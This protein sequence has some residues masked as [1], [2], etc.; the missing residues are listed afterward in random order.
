MPTQNILIE[1]TASAE[2]LNVGIDALLRLGKIDQETADKFT[3]ANDALKQRQIL[4][5]GN[6]TAL[7]KFIGSLTNAQKAAVGDTYNKT[8]TQIKTQLASVN[9]EAKEFYTE[10][11]RNATAHIIPGSSQEELLAALTVLGSANQSLKE[12]GGQEDVVV[13]KTQRATTQLREMRQELLVLEESGSGFSQKFGLSFDQLS[14]KAAKLQDR[15]GDTSARIQHMASDTFPLQAFVGAL[16]GVA[17][18]FNVASGAAILFGGNQEE[19]QQAILKVQGAMQILNGLESISAL[20][21]DQSVAKTGLQVLVKKLF[22]KT[23]QE[24]VVS[25]QAESESHIENA[26]AMA[27][28][29]AARLK[30]IAAIEAENAAKAAAPAKQVL[31]EV[32]A[33]ITQALESAPATG[34]SATNTAVLDAN[35]ASIEANNAAKEQQI[36]V[37]EGQTGALAGETTGLIVESGATDK[38][39]VAQVALNTAM[40]LNP[41][42]LVLAGILALAA[43]FAVYEL[44]IKQVS[45][46]EENRLGVMEATNEASKKAADSIAK[47]EGNLNILLA[48]AKNVSLSTTERQIALDKITTSY[49]EYLSSLTLDN[50][51]TKQ[52]A[53]LIDNQIKLLKERAFVQAA[54]D[55]YVEKL[56]KVVEAETELNRV[57]EEG[58]TFWEKTKAAVSGLVESH[59]GLSLEEIVVAKKTQDVTEATKK[60]NQGFEALQKG[61]DAL[62][63]GFEAGIPII[64]DYTQSVLAFQQAA[65]KPFTPFIPAPFKPFDPAIFDKEKTAALAAAQYRI[66]VAKKG[67]KEEFNARRDLANLDLK[68]SKDDARILIDDKL[69]AEGKYI[70]T[71]AGLDAEAR[72]KY[73][74][75]T[76]AAS[77]AIVLQQEALGKEGSEAF[78]NARRDVLIKTAKEARTQEGITAGEI[79]Q[80]NAQLNLDLLNL[81]IERANKQLN[82]QKTLQQ[83]KLDLAQKGG[84]DELNAQIAILEIEK[85]IEINNTKGNKDAIAEIN[86]RFRITEFEKIQAFNQ[87]VNEDEIN[88]RIAG[89]NDNISKLRLQGEKDTDVSIIEEKKKLIEQQGALEIAGVQKSLLTESQK[90]DAILAIY[91][92]ELVDKKALEDAKAQVELDAFVRSQQTALEAQ[93]LSITAESGLAAAFGAERNKINHDLLQNELDNIEVLRQANLQKLVEKRQNQ[94]DFDATAAD[95]DNKDTQ[96]K[97]NN[98]ERVNQARQAAI[99]TYADLLGKGLGIVFDK[100]KQQLQES[101]ANNQALLDKKLIS[102]DEF[103]KRQKKIKQDEAAIERRK[104]LLD[105]AIDF[106]KQFFFIKAQVA[107]LLANPLTSPL[108]LG[109]L[110]QLGLIVASYAEALS[111]IGGQKFKKGKINIIGPGSETSDSIP[112]SIS[113]HESVINAFST[114]ATTTINRNSKTVKIKNED[115]LTAINENRLSEFLLNIILET[116]EIVLTVPSLINNKYI[117]KNESV[118][119]SPST[120]LNTNGK[121]INIKNGD[122][123]TAISEHHFVDLL[124]SIFSQFDMPEVVFNIPELKNVNKNQSDTTNN[125]I[126]SHAAN[127]TTTIKNANGKTISIKNGDVLNAISENNFA[128]F[129]MNIIPE[130]INPDIKNISQLAD[131]SLSQLKIRNNESN[132]I[133]QSSYNYKV[134]TS[135]SISEYLSKIINTAT[136][137][138]VRDISTNNIKSISES[139]LQNLFYEYLSNAA[140][141]NSYSNIYN[142]FVTANSTD[143]SNQFKT[144]NEYLLSSVPKIDM[145]DFVTQSFNL[146]VM[147]DLPKWVDRHIAHESHTTNYDSHTEIDYE[148]L[149]KEV[150]KHFNKA[151][152]KA[153]GVEIGFDHDGMVAFIKE[154]SE[155]EKYINRRRGFKN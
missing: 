31:G 104:A 44:A 78:F 99:N 76:I 30:A 43:G 27:I 88:T 137:N 149:G 51:L 113:N 81:D 94:D 89:I 71:V 74:K 95:L 35:T 50:V 20:I 155:M 139:N 58:V 138:I 54:Q 19:V 129:M 63:K 17:A 154:K 61:N 11:A 141:N 87:R 16:T 3:K 59:A 101:A 9:V 52:S 29:D 124:V 152:E 123:V 62:A 32:A 83:D 34:V 13:Q 145:P 37:T 5:Q 97:L 111:K 103:N 49:P 12:F 96:A 110:A 140:Y 2:G 135:K 148:R 38:A 117:I 100:E 53:G 134:G 132:S 118:V 64:E 79:K 55:L 25:I 119:N 105:I 121:T 26:A 143:L 86:D 8:L 1:F 108:A 125:N 127:S 142:D 114:L 77:Q 115:I 67:S 90:A 106:A 41:L 6:E 70:N 116:P 47:E 136:N 39:A 57:N 147:N 36:A 46:E 69:A 133:L 65:S 98:I 21:A 66:D 73:F 45:D 153:P 109:A 15:I 80:I 130:F 84:L 92:R 60:A 72:A 122:V 93:K 18:G 23:T 75:D 33:P 40:E 91:D 68:L 42:G 28:E 151:L 22:T 131:N 146:P 7:T 107:V 144:Y 85:Q 128:D 126:N 120:I 112:S 10:I 102:Q 14:I 4:L 56:K 82:D 150:G 48:T 24:E